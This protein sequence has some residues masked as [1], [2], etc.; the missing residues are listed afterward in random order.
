MIGLKQTRHVQFLHRGL[1]LAAVLF[2]LVTIIAG[3]SVLAGFNPGYHPF[4]PLL[5]YNTAMGVAYIAAGVTAWRNVALS[6]YAAA[7]IFAFNCLVLGIIGYLYVVGTAVAIESIYAM[8][9]RVV[10][11]LVLFL[12]LVWVGRR[13]ILTGS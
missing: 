8:F 5:S 1:S 2:G 3:V 10:A 9:F 7:A 12:G 6:C 13:K 11:W 4:L